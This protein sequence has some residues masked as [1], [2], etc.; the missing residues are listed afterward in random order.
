[1]QAPRETPQSAF[2]YRQASSLIGAR[3]TISVVP[4]HWIDCQ[5]EPGAPGEREFNMDVCC[6]FRSLIQAQSTGY[7]CGCLQ[8]AFWCAARGSIW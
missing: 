6:L 8:S 1:M 4:G 5:S 3:D 2:V 7:L